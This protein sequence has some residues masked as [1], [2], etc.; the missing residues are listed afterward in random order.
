MT[1][2]GDET[3]REATRRI[4]E[5]VWNDGELDAIDE[6]LA[7]EYV[8]R[9]AGLPEAIRGPEGFRGVVQQFRGAFPDIDWTIE[10]LLAAEDMVSLH[11]TVRGTHEG[12][13]MG[14]APT[15]NEVEFMG[16]TLLRFEGGKAVEDWGIYDALGM[17]QQLGVVSVPQ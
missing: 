12:E 7:E 1:T 8:M 5:E 10:H 3:N 14:I 9:N 4:I 15:G 17:M 2:P 6:L 16:M 11:Y 13:L